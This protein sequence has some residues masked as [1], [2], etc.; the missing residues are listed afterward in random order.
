MDTN[1]K[2]NKG[3]AFVQ[4]SDV[5]TAAKA[6]KEMNLK[7]VLGRPIAVDWAVSKGQYDLMQKSNGMLR[8]V[9][10]FLNHI[11]VRILFVIF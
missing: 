7:V 5:F 10:I 1:H 6:M 4:F 3:F 9:K 11:Q 8:I 2:R